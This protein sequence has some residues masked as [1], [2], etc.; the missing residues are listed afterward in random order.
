MAHGYDCSSFPGTN[1]A[2]ENGSDFPAACLR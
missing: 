1:V 2:V